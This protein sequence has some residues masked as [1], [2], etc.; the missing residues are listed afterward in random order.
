VWHTSIFFC[1]GWKKKMSDIYF[2]EQF[3][4]MLSSDVLTKITVQQISLQT[5]GSQPFW[6]AHV[7]SLQQPEEK[8]RKLQT[9]ESDTD[10][11][12]P[13]K[14]PTRTMPTKKKSND[15]KRPTKKQRTKKR[16]TL[17]NASKEEEDHVRKRPTKKKPSNEQKEEDEDAT[18][19][20]TL[21]AVKHVQKEEETKTTDTKKNSEY[22]NL[23][24]WWQTIGPRTIS[25]VTAKPQA[26]RGNAL[27]IVEPGAKQPCFNLTL[28]YIK[29]VMVRTRPGLASG[30]SYGNEALFKQVC[31][32]FFFSFEPHLNVL[33]F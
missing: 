24:A 27:T 12:Q 3:P 22:R 6:M 21:P 20:E 26:L 4:S 29:N 5:T 17:K 1:L 28:H 14:E 7:A 31:C 13:K 2:S 19:D 16:P 32:V 30:A 15:D 8:R 11:D 23:I 18:E 33:L 10:D 25:M 9:Q